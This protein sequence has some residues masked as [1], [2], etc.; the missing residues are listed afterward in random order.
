ML[1]AGGDSYWEM[2]FSSAGASRLFCAQRDAGGR[3]PHPDP[4]SLR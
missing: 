1:I 4:L 3:A 2:V